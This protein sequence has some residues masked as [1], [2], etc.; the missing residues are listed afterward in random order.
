MVIA[1]WTALAAS[2][3]KYCL[4]TALIADTYWLYFWGQLNYTT[5]QSSARQG[6]REAPYLFKDVHLCCKSQVS[7]HS[8]FLL[9]RWGAVLSNSYRCLLTRDAITPALETNSRASFQPFPWHLHI[10]QIIGDDLHQQRNLNSTKRSPSNSQCH[11]APIWWISHGFTT[12]E[13]E[14]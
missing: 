5:D 6:N 1:S 3:Y 14:H 4:R 12:Y 8:P 9:P 11:I 13:W 10:K 2:W 7:L